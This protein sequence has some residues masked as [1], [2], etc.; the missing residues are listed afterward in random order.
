M[1]LNG[2]GKTSEF[3]IHRW[4]AKNFKTILGSDY[5]LSNF[6]SNPKHQPDVWLVKESELVPVEIKS[7]DFTGK[8]L[9]Q[10]K[11]YMDFYGTRDG[12]AVARG[13]K[14]EL[15]QNIKFLNYKEWQ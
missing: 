7:G 11:R 12:I 8:G 4:F 10:L 9:S 2:Y 3:D 14:C 5:E 13:L 6:K 15:Q 1:N